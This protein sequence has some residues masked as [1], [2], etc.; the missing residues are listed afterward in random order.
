M[1]SR[2][3]TRGKVRLQVIL[4]HSHNRMALS[5]FDHSRAV[6]KSNL[7]Q[8]SL[9][10]EDSSELNWVEGGALRLVEP[11]AILLM[12]FGAVASEHCYADPITVVVDDYLDRIST[13]VGDRVFLTV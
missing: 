8:V 13:A 1:K 6:S 11:L 5:L 3:V 7:S 4:F 10:D 9:S 2:S 12:L